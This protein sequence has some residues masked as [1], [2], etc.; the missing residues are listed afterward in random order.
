M[1][2]I[3]KYFKSYGI[4]IEKN[5]ILFIKDVKIPNFYKENKNNIIIKWEFCHLLY[6]IFSSYLEKNTIIYENNLYNISKN[7]IVLDCGAN[8][9]LFSAYAASKG[10]I[11]YSFE[12]MS[13][14][15]NNF[16]NKTKNIYKNINIVP[17]GLKEK[18]KIEK[19]IQCDNPGASHDINININ[20]DNEILYME[21]I[22]CISLDF[23]CNFYNIKP[24]FIKIDV[25]GSEEQLLYGSKQIL[26]EYNPIVSLGLYHKKEDKDI[27]PKIIKNINN[28]YNFNFYIGDINSLYLF[29]N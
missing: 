14:T 2:S 28:N 17:Y 19:F 20:L 9:G 6:K 10:A 15:R 7:D 3:I 1:D 16:L 26:Q 21:D 29:C 25:E 4:D 27:I 13:Y 12:P 5:D 23:F 8:M 11:V 22:Q 18:N 24:T